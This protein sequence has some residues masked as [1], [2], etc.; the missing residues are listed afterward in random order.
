[1]VVNGGDTRGGGTGADAW[2]RWIAKGAAVVAELLERIRLETER[3][4]NFL[5]NMCRAMEFEPFFSGD[6]SAMRDVS[7][8]PM[9]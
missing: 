7:K 6:E 4:E 2:D 9:Q 1:M 8:M 5:E 3:C